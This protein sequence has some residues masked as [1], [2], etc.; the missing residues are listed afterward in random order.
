MLRVLV[1]WAAP[2][3]ALSGMGVQT[4]IVLGDGYVG[5]N[6]NILVAEQEQLGAQANEVG[7]R[8]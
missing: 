7:R 6:C 8:G 3:G 2:N 5:G 4:N 1:E